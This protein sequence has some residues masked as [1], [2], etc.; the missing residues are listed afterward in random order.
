MNNYFK[1]GFEKT[2]SGG[3]LYH[4]AELAGLGALALPSALHL[5]TG[6]DMKAKPYHMLET[7]G[8]GILAAPSVVSLLKGLS[9]VK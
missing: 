3:K 1:T 5:A 7:A 6:K 8:L 4:A 2:A 9:K